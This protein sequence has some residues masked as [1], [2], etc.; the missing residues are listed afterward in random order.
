MWRH[1]WLQGEGK[2]AAVQRDSTSAASTISTSPQIMAILV[3]LLIAQDAHTSTILHPLFLLLILSEAQ[4]PLKVSLRPSSTLL[5]YSLPFMSLSFLS[6]PANP[7]GGQGGKPMWEVAGRQRQVL[8]P[9]ERGWPSWWTYWLL[10]KMASWGIKMDLCQ[11][12]PLFG[13][14]YFPRLLPYSVKRRENDVRSREI[15]MEVDDLHFSGLEP[16]PSRLIYGAPLLRQLA[17]NLT[18]QPGHYT[19]YRLATAWDLSHRLIFED[20]ACAEK[21]SS[22]IVLAGI[23]VHSIE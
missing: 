20:L 17:T 16:H 11:R 7:M 12:L 15:G 4:P 1:H 18:L 19:E 10:S 5:S 6:F 9:V 8:E 3:A 13:R 22:G 23:L 21:T 2:Q 14:K